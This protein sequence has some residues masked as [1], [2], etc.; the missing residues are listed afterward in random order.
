MAMAAVR[1]SSTR[2]RAAD[3]TELPLLL[4]E[5]AE[6][7]HVSAGVV[8]FHGG[9]LHKGSPDSL[10]AHC[11]ELASRGIFAASAGY[12]LLG[13]GAASIDDCVADVRRATAEFQRLAALRGIDPNRLAAG[14]SSAGAHLAL[15][16]AMVADTSAASIPAVATLVAL[17]PAG[18][19]LRSLDA[20]VHARLERQIGI[21]T[22]RLAEYSMIEHVRLGTPPLLIQHGTADE[23]ESIETVR[24]FRD[25]LVRAGNVCKLL[26]YPDAKHA[27]HYPESGAHFPTVIEATANFVLTAGKLLPRVKTGG[28]TR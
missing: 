10:A 15:V 1:E 7:A 27:F 21:A 24:R 6:G 17:N 22:G 25:A 3:G 23:V 4:F 11:R 2:Y 26:E 16:A 5:P 8:L 9:A 14:G 20:S 18:L 28:A 12:R 13:Q 19:D